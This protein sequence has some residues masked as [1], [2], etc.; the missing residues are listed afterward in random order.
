MNKKNCKYHLQLS[1]VHDKNGIESQKAPLEFDFESH[2]DIFFIIDYL[3]ND[4]RFEDKQQI[5]E[6]IVG[7]KLFGG[8][9]LK[10]KDSELFKSFMPAFREF[11]MKL[12]NK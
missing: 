9:M 7:L 8:V 2:D 4:N 11:M 12:K 6:L 1:M 3:Q 10:N 5:T